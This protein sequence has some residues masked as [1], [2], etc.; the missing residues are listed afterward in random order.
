MI[1]YTIRTKAKSVNTMKRAVLFYNGD[2]AHINTV[3]NHLQPDDYIICADGGTNLALKYG[4][5][6]DVIIGDLDSLSEEVQKKLKNTQVEWVTFPK[7]KNETDSELA[8]Q[9]AVKKGYKELLI[10]GFFGSRLDH[11]LT[12]LFALDF[13]YKHA[14]KTTFIEGTQEISLITDTLKVTGKP[15]D[16][17]SLIPFKDDVENVITKDLQYP[18]KNET[19]F[20]G[21]S[22]G[23]S[24][25]MSKSVA[26]ISVKKGMLLIIHTK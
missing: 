2:L 4:L 7:E 1:V 19:L 16:L 6:P 11:M 22:R 24:N 15:G 20:F 9:F 23:I 14:I 5:T 25:V 10:F 12:N 18:L 3:K 13:L 17:V 26:E 8:L 21:R